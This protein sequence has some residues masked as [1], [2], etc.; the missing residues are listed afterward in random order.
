MIRQDWLDNLNLQAPQTTDELYT[1]AK[2]FTD[3]DPDQN[4]KN[5]TYGI[6]LTNTSMGWGLAGAGGIEQ[7]FGLSDNW[8]K[9]DSKYVSP[10]ICWSNCS[11]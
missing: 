4:G 10:C 11:G 1:V 9:Q 7:A 2:A 6:Q 3:N 5:D 8:V